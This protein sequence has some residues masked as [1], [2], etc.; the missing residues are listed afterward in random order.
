MCADGGLFARAGGV[1]GSRLEQC[2]GARSR[3]TGGKGAEVCVSVSV[4]GGRA[5]FSSKHARLT[6][7]RRFWPTLFQ[8]KLTSHIRTSGSSGTGAGPMPSWAF[9]SGHPRGGMRLLWTLDLRLSHSPIIG[10]VLYRRA[11]A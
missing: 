3:G 8:G 9:G 10:K 4:R 1:Q 5:P 7:L 2:A 11:P 6:F